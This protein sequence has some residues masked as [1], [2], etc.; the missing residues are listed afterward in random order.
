MFYIL[1]PYPWYSALS[2][3]NLC[4]GRD[5]RTC[6]PSDACHPRRARRHLPSFLRS[7]PVNP[8][9][10]AERCK[11]CPVALVPILSCPGSSSQPLD[12]L[13]SAL[14]GTIIPGSVFKLKSKRSVFSRTRLVIPQTKK[15]T[16]ST[17]P[18]RFRLCLHE[19]APSRRESACLPL[20]APM[21]THPHRDP[22]PKRP[23]AVCH[24]CPK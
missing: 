12:H 22:G 8:V 18:R 11:P 1:E 13:K 16:A 20:Y 5:S 10:R 4:L 24:T 19:R 14:S 6:C 21:P 17:T 2:P 9:P 7:I 3:K 23:R 15:H